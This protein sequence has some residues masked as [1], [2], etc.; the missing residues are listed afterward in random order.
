MP[1]A[2]RVSV[3]SAAMIETI[4]PSDSSSGENVL[5]TSAQTA[6]SAATHNA[7]PK[8]V[9]RDIHKRFGDNEVL[10]GVSLA[11]NAGDVISIIGSSGSG[12]STFLRCINFLE[13]PN[14]GDIIVDG[15]PVR[16][17]TDSRGNLEVADHKQ[18]QRVRTKL[19]M[20]FQHFNLW[21]H[22]TS[23]ENVMEAPMHVLGLSKKEASERA[24][25]C[26][27]K[28]GLAPKV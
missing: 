19:A 4:G 17:K 15:E 1:E 18:L 26:L 22:M 13:R 12:K 28:V 23:I 24:R 21:A 14:A 11:A 8:L 25:E 10:K 20:V 2:R 5:D 3:E 16:T 27:E 6:A 9:A 7:A